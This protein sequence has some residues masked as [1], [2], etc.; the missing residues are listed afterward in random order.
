ML[1]FE[2]TAKQALRQAFRNE[3]TIKGCWFLFCQAIL[4][5]L[6]KIGLKEE[7][8]N[9]RFWVKLFMALALYPIDFIEQ[10][11]EIIVSEINSDRKVFKN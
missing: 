5:N 11:A 7:Y 10:E 9:T 4:T 6:G 8:K 3:V 2:L 1:D